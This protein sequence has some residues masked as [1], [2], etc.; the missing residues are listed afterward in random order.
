MTDPTRTNEWQWLVEKAENMP[1]LVRLFNENASRTDDFLIDFD[2]LCFDYAKQRIDN[3]TKEKL[4]ALAEKMHLS[5]AINDLVSGEKV[6]I[7]EDR[8]ALHSALRLPKG[9]SLVVDNVDIA[10]QVQ[11][12][13]NEVA[14]IVDRL[15]SGV[16]RGYEG[17]KITDVVN[18]GVGGSDLGPLMT[19][20]AL[21]SYTGGAQAAERGVP[22]HEINTHFVSNMDGT[23]LEKLLA[24]LNPVT[25]VFIIS[26]KSFTTSDTF[27]N[28]ETSLNWLM[29]GNANRELIKRNHFIGISAK[30]DKMDAWGIHKA[31]QL[32]LWDWVGG[33]FSMWSAIGLAVALRIGMGNFR[34]LLAGAHV[35]DE[36]FIHTPF[37]NNIPVMMG[38][39]GVWNSSFLNISAHAV[40]PYDGRLQYFPN[41]LIQLEME[42]NGKSVNVKGNHIDFD[43]CPILLGDIGSNAQH[44][45][46][47][48]LHQG[49]QSVACDFIACIDRY[50]DCDKQM[51]SS[52]LRQHKLSLANCLAQSRVLAFGNEAISSG[53]EVKDKQ[54]NADLH[55]YYHGNQPSSTILFNKLTPKTLGMLIAMYEHKVYVMS[56]IW[57]INPFDQWGVEVGKVMATEL[58]EAIDRQHLNYDASTNA[59]IKRINGT[60]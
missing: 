6:N 18:I 43:T 47:Q 3:S 9:A 21:S 17:N 25:T 45:F 15:T 38:L 40:L 27:S 29:Q 22:Y 16:W 56:R 7:T 44:A 8:P 2:E 13:L 19:C 37:E 36:H 10:E 31:N 14:I 51:D 34:D 26:S 24:H 53:S 4:I 32:K 35:M 20:T 12:S 42:S 33:R 57:G 60:L 5:Q 28:A 41:Y 23:Q 46:Y 48:L 59:L 54:E 50:D 49:T 58:S 1:D 52:L 30:P 11:H 55:K 39:L